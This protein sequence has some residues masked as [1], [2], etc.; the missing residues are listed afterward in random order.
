MHFEWHD[1]ICFVNALIPSN[2]WPFWCL[3]CLLFNV[4][5]CLINAFHRSHWIS[6]NPLLLVLLGSFCHLFTFNLYTYFTTCKYV[7]VIS[8]VWLCVPRARFSICRDGARS[9]VVSTI[10][11]RSGLHSRTTPRTSPF[12]TSYGVSFVSYICENYCDISREH[13]ILF[14]FPSDNSG[15]QLMLFVC[16][17]NWR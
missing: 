15:Y 6:P 4:I 14:L 2:V 13:D 5:V 7:S 1:F 9:K 16:T 17:C 10:T 3:R 8:C 11:L 12:W